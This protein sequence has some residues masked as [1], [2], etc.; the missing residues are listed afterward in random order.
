MGSLANFLVENILNEE[1]N[2]ITA[3]FGG[4]FKPPT[5]GH[6]EVVKKAINNNPEI[7]KVIIYVGGKVRNGVTQDQ[8]IEIWNKFYKPQINKPV[9]ILPSVAPV[10][11]IYRYAKNN[12]EETVYWVIGAREGREDDLKDIANRSISIDKYPNLQLKTTSTP[13]GGMS[14]TNARKAIVNNNFEEFERYLPDNVDKNA[15]WDILTKQ[16]LN[17]ADP[18]TGTGKKPKGSGRRLYT[19]EDPSDTVKVKFSSRQDIVD[20]LRLNLMLANHKLLI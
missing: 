20:T 17:E 7:D 10:K 15:I 18:K 2:P 12:P 8:A 11:D 5:A 14:G 6:L 13:D 9:E 1:V 4:G 19:D 16:E 3:L